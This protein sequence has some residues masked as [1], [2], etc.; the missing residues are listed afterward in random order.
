M[1]GMSNETYL[2]LSGFT[3]QLFTSTGGFDITRVTTDSVSKVT[4]VECQTQ[5]SPPQE[6]T[7]TLSPRGV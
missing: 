3:I 4:T 1:A 5:D 7:L 6:F 2:R